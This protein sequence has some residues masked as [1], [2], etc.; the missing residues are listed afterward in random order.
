MSTWDSIDEV[1]SPQDFVAVWDARCDGLPPPLLSRRPRIA[2]PPSGE[3]PH[4]SRQGRKCMCFHLSGRD[5]Q[6]GMLSMS[7]MLQWNLPRM[8]F[9]SHRGGRLLWCVVYDEVGWIDVQQG[10]WT[11]HTRVQRPKRTRSGGR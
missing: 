5:V 6:E 7:A 4:P 1:E 3:H 11:A 2:E 10:T 9:D 8:L